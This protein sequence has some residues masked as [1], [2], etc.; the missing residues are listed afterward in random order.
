[1]V[2][3][4]RLVL[5]DASTTFV[6]CLEQLWLVLLLSIEKKGGAFLMN[7]K[8]PSSKNLTCFMVYDFGVCC[9][10]MTQKPL[11]VQQSCPTVAGICREV[12]ISRSVHGGF[13]IGTRVVRECWVVGRG[14]L[15][16]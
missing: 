8:L 5:G 15:F 10:V 1:M 6:C 4:G 16:P 14:F 9:S 11:E 7:S 2:M 3:G 13:S 12:R